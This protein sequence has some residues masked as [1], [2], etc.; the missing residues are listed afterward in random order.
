[1]PYLSYLDQS[2][3]FWI[4]CYEAKICIVAA[5]VILH[6][7]LILGVS[8]LQPQYWHLHVGNRQS[9]KLV[10][11]HKHQFWTTKLINEDRYISSCTTK[12]SIRYIPQPSV[13]KN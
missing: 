8:D 1:M 5:L 2:S 9:L 6:S 11:Q 7:L 10:P 3:D 4:F 12:A 13:V